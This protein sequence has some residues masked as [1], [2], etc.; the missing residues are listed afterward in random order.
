[1]RNHKYFYPLLLFVS[2]LLIWE[3][4]SYHWH[5][6][7]FILPSPSK[8]F[9]D[10]VLHPHEYIAHSMVT[11]EEI[12]WS[13]LLAFCISFPVAWIMNYFRSARLALQPLFVM[14]QCIPMF[15]LAP[16][17][18]I[19]LGWSMSAIVMPTALMIFF[20]LTLNIYQGLRST[21][22]SLLDFFTAHQATEWQTFFKLRLPWSL[23]HTFAGLRIATAVAGISAIAGEWAGGQQGLGV[24]MH[25]SRYT[26]DIIVTFGALFC[27]AI[28]SISLY[29]TI[30]I[31]EKAVFNPRKRGFALNKAFYSWIII[32]LI[33]LLCPGCQKDQP[34]EA[35]LL[36]DWFPNVN[37][38]PLYVG[39]QK[40]FFQQNGINLKIMKLRD[41]ADSIPYISSGQASLAI[42][43]MPHFIRTIS[44]QPVNSKVVGYLVKEPLEVLLFRKD[45]NIK[46]IQDFQDKT[47]GFPYKGFFLSKI[48]QVL[49]KQNISIKNTRKINFDIVTSLA[50]NL[51]D[52]STGAY[53]NIE[54]AHLEYLGIDT[55]FI[56]FS[57][58]DIPNYHEMIILANNN[59]LQKNT[60][61]PEKFRQ[62]LDESIKFCKKYPEKAFEIYSKVNRRKNCSTTHWEEKAWNN[63]YPLLAEDQDHE[64]TCWYE[65]SLWMYDN[66]LIDNIPNIDDI[67]I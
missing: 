28:I 31:I 9:F 3:L 38:I 29:G 23:P 47:I 1:M 24:L 55:D 14:I 27:L 10:V 40:N 44:K 19:W 6:L 52:I 30:L 48:N 43:Y 22:R 59:F 7:T 39:I 54:C 15:T 56:P 8:I 20:P 49:Q 11:L 51:I 26:A 33:I 34:S 46:G 37:H 60:D 2:L 61:F 35:R 62:A 21:P 50:T 58:F 25:E 41:P 18:I 16:I 64:H 63:T 65:F 13:L 12:G 66:N 53:W 5:K 4:C 67:L 17:M 45:N 42:Y 32:P 57:E 36:L